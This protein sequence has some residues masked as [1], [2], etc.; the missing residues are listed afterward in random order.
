MRRGECG[1][2]HG[3]VHDYGQ[4][5]DW[6]HEVR[7]RGKWSRVR[8]SGREWQ[9]IMAVTLP[10]SSQQKRLDHCGVDERLRGN[11]GME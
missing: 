1:R 8:G 6:N 5:R 2:E 4:G 3:H 11:D 7:W 10:S 9:L